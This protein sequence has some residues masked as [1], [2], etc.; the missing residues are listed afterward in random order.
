M[1]DMRS[2]YLLDSA[3]EY[4]LTTCFVALQ[5]IETMDVKKISGF[6]QS[7]QDLLVPNI[8]HTINQ[9]AEID[10]LGD[11]GGQQIQSNSS[12]EGLKELKGL[13][14]SSRKKFLKFENKDAD[15]IFLSDINGFIYEY[16]QLLKNYKKI[17][18]AVESLIQ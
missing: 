5:Y 1:R 12:I 4:Y 14:Y 2:P 8:D 3:S 6:E 15:N 7:I 13:L 16:Q 10:L 11:F 17:S 9:S 18:S